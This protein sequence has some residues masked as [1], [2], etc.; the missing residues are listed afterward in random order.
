MSK[1]NRAQKCLNWKNHAKHSL[2]LNY[3]NSINPT[4]PAPFIFFILFLFCF[5]LFF[6]YEFCLRWR[7][8][9][10]FFFILCSKSWRIYEAILCL[11]GHCLHRFFSLLK[12]I[13]RLKLTSIPTN[14]GYVQSFLWVNR[15][16]ENGKYC[17]ESYHKFLIRF[18]KQRK[19]SLAAISPRYT[20]HSHQH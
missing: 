16:K 7:K 12:T 19:K 3:I 11:W 18:T 20:K 2:M 5:V 8:G 6:F 13:I 1:G 9:E 4:L 14:S 10:K 17:L 15:K